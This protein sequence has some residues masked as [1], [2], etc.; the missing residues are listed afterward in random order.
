LRD[1]VVGVHRAR[2]SQDGTLKKTVEIYEYLRSDAFGNAIARIQDRIVR[3]RTVLDRERSAHLSWWREREESDAVIF[4][5][6]GNIE[7]RIKEIIVSPDGRNAADNAA[8]DVA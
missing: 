5:E 4:R 7:S 1:A 2:L 3:N 6:A 8:A